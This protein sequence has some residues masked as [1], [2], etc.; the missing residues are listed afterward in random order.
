VNSCGDDLAVEAIRGRSL[1]FGAKCDWSRSAPAARP[2]SD[3]LQRAL[4]A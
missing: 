1:L 2:G 3:F 4:N